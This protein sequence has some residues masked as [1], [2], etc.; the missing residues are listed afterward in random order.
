MKLFISTF[1]FLIA[2]TF[3][4]NSYSAV[5]HPKP[6]GEVIHQN[7]QE[8]VITPNSSKDRTSK[9][10]T[11]AERRALRKDLKSQLKEQR[12]SSRGV[13]VEL[14]LFVVLALI[15]PPLAMFLYEGEASGRFWISLG[16]LL[17]A[18]PLWGRLGALA[19]LASVIYTLYVII[20]EAL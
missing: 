11:R 19:I 12:K 7:D 10:S 5:F 17:L 8:S 9:K 13:E 1:F 16:L 14:I 15:L 18:I 4:T 3:S 6:A 20:S 2:F